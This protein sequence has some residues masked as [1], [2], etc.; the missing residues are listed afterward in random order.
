MSFL[1]DWIANSTQADRDQYITALK[2]Q[3]YSI[4]RKIRNKVHANNP[5]WK[6]E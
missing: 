1:H 5:Q 6:G 3:D 4:V 2:E